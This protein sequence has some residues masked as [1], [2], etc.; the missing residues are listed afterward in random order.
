M[1]EIICN[2]WSLVKQTDH[3]MKVLTDNHENINE[4]ITAK[5]NGAFISFCDSRIY[6]CSSTP[7]L[8]W[9]KWTRGTFLCADSV[10]QGLL[11]CGGVVPI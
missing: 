1:K 10:K 2:F 7:P 9:I 5:S 8:R 6:Q 11:E 3:P 4:K